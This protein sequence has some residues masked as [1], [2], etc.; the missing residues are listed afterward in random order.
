MSMTVEE[1]R[2]VFDGEFATAVAAKTTAP[3]GVLLLAFGPERYALPLST[4]SSIHAEPKLGAV[5][6][7]Q[8]ALIGLATVRN[9]IVPV[10]D[11][12]VALGL[13]T[14][15]TPAHWLVIG[16]GDAPVG[17]AFDTLEGHLRIDPPASGT[18]G[19][20]MDVAGISRHVIDLEE[21]RHVQ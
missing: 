14:V 9:Q 3:I 4:V 19:N 11:L 17:W 21:L 12:A 10:F 2:A 5:P 13:R 18:I 7:T 16:R 6:S 8:R 20:R 1:M 15:A